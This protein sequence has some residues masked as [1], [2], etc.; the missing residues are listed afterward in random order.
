MR[1]LVSWSFL[2]HFQLKSPIFLCPMPREF[3]FLVKIDY[4]TK[5]MSIW[6]IWHEIHAIRGYIH[7]EFIKQSLDHKEI[8][9]SCLLILTNCYSLRGFVNISTSRSFVLTKSSVMS[10]FCTWSQRKWCLISICL[11]L[12]CY[13]R[14]FEIFMALVL[15]HLI[16]T[17]SK[18]KLK[19][20]RWCLFFYLILNRTLMLNSVKY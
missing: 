1:F 12:E 11:V 7:Q 8:T 17:C 20:L 16:G 15:S 9:P 19:S 5:Y 3:L 18:D 2:Y 10:P 14:F 4:L 6:C 13:M